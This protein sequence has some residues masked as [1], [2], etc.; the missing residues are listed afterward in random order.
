M[1][2]VKNLHQLE[3][4]DAAELA[5]AKVSELERR[6]DHMLSVLRRYVEALGGE[7]EIS[8]IFDKKRIR[9]KGV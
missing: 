6:D 1:N 3:V 2:D 5:Q 4:A 8:A 9:L 7:L